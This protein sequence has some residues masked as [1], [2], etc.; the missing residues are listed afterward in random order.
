M[1]TGV[2]LASNPCGR[3]GGRGAAW[4]TAWRGALRGARRGG[5]G[6]AAVARRGGRGMAGAAWRPWQGEMTE[7][8]A[9][10]RGGR[11]E[12]R[13]G[14]LPEGKGR[15][16][17]RDS[18]PRSSGRRRRR[19]APGDGDGGAPGRRRWRGFSVSACVSEASCG[20]K[21]PEGLWYRFLLR[22]GTKGDL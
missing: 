5:R 13:R 8:R 16:A 3:G 20:R 19:G 9:W 11:G 18:A 12:A 14:A 2:A 21:R 22:T 6:V 1:V 7:L 10:R 15:G 17:E 4:S